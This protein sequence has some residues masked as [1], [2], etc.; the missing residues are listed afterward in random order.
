[1]E[2]NKITL[3]CGCLR[4]YLST[5][6][7][8]CAFITLSLLFVATL[9]AQVSVVP[10]MQE[11]TVSRGSTA[12]FDLRLHNGGKGPL[13]ITLNVREMEINEEGVPS[14][15]PVKPAWSCTDWITLKPGEFT[16]QPDSVL[17]VHGR[18]AAPKDASG[19]H[20]AYITCDFLSKMTPFKLGD[21]DD[22]QMQIDMSRGV[23]SNLFV[24]V[25]STENTVNLKP[26]TLLL[27]SGQRK[28]TAS[29]D[30]RMNQAG[31]NWQ[32]VLPV[33]NDGN[34][35]TVVTGMAGIWNDAARLID[36]AA[37]QAGRGFVL[38]GKTRIFRAV[39][40][41]PLPDGSYVVKI[42]LKH[43]QTNRLSEGMFPFSVVDGVAIPGAADPAITKV[44]KGA[45][46]SFDLSKN[47]VD[48]KVAPHSQRT[49][50]VTI[51]NRTSETIMVYGRLA[52]WAIND[53]GTVSLN[54]PASM[55][56][57]PCTSWVQI[58]P[59]PLVLD[60]KQ[61]G[62]V[63]IIVTAPAEVEGEYYA[64]AVFETPDMPKDLPD[65]LVV[66][67]TVLIPVVGST[68]QRIKAEVK[69]SDYKPLGPLNRAFAVRL[70]N[71]GNTHCYANGE[72]TIYDE[73]WNKV[74]EKAAFGGTE[75]FVL[76]GQK[77]DFVITCPG[78]LEP[79]SYSAAVEVGYGLKK[80]TT[81]EYF[82]KS[83]EK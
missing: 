33:H 65:E 39:G 66:P 20:Y 16:L 42:Q 24:T 47:L 77:R 29:L 18:V 72:L 13:T 7:A 19:G 63:K 52:T 14:T 40:A 31:G 67:R 57:K 35:H 37:L 30:P 21:K 61:S 9:H 69:V 32:V 36:R 60:P 4:R 25:R 5:V 68:N 64:A 15:A 1:M 10:L 50:G 53:S 73:K 54:P 22:Q 11:V 79:G 83:T 23:S 3:R 70:E 12:T 74:L 82:F 43:G 62:S 51:T 58:L 46:P 81:A 55:T 27:S 8:K 48:F 71:Q 2:W 76:P 45:T 75:E 49:Q 34:I 26:D 44:L 17:V 38:P 41:K 78:A 56:V 28:A 6:V 59:N 80:S